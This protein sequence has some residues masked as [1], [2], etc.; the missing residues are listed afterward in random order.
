[1]AIATGPGD[2]R[3]ALFAL[4][5]A[6]LLAFAAGCASLW[7]WPRWPDWWLS[8]VVLAFVAAMSVAAWAAWCRQRWLVPVAAMLLG[9][10]WS[11]AQVERGLSQRLPA[12]L[13]AVD[14]V[15]EGHVDD[16][17]QRDAE[18]VR[19]RFCVQRAW[20]GAE[21]LALDGCWRLA[22]YAPR[23]VRVS[24]AQ[25][26]DAVPRIE[27]GQRW[28]L[29]VRLRRPRGLANPG[30]ADS[31]RKALETG[32][33]AAGY[34][35]AAGENVRL[36]AAGGI[37]ALRAGISDRIDDA[38][39]HGRERTAALLRGLAVGDRRDFDDR[40]WETL[41]RTG[42][43]HLFSIS[44][45]HVGMVAIV[46]AAL[47]TVLI[48]PWPRLLRRAPRRLWLLL[49]ALAAAF[50]YALLAGFEVPTQ[51][52]VLMIAAG[53]VAL[54]SRR[55]ICAWQAWCVALVLVLVIDPLAVLA[56]GFW[57]SFGGVAWLILAGTQQR[58]QGHWRRAAQVQWAV[59]LGLLPLGAGF[60]AQASWISPLV[61]GVAIPWITLG[62]VPP[63]LLS[64]ALEPM[65][66]A[67]AAPL[68]ALS[69]WL[70]EW[71]MAG[72]D[73]IAALS[74]TAS[75]LPEPGAL[76]IAAALL[77]ALVA[78]LP[79]AWPLRLL[80][81]PLLLPLLLPHHDRPPPGRFDLQV[82]DVGQGTAVL[83]RTARHALLFDAGPAFP[84]RRDLGE[85][86]VLP[87]L[88][89]LGVQR[90]DAL[91]L[92]HADLDH[93]GGG[94]AIL[95]ALPVTRVLAGE[96]V[97]GIDADA[98]HEHDAW[99]WDGVAFRL[100]HPP[101]GYP[102]RGNERSCV[103]HVRGVVG[104]A[105][106]TGDAGDIAELR[107]LNLHRDRLRAEV[108]LLGHH[109]SD[110]SSSAALL[111]AVQPRW[112]LASAGYRNR[113]GHPDTY[114]LRRLAWRGIAVASTIEAGAIH[115]QWPGDAIRVLGRRQRHPRLWHE[116]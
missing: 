31:E 27:P 101:P 81:L 113:F 42:T 39:G 74:W 8:P 3:A 48:W 46:V 56:I 36:S 12:A 92:S 38:L 53:G 102:T 4:T 47:A 49:P 7:L 5:P 28:R 21:S 45:L 18:A 72:L 112:A 41:R 1:M 91:L 30:G 83:V 19:F 2:T 37:H 10:A 104:S 55:R 67:V 60:F 69:A 99:D 75:V 32:L 85:T 50:G 100:L 70:L 77:A 40:D 87:A 35:R 78:L 13:E 68:L 57:L 103:L 88:R 22:W 15:A 54:A 62:V 44:G 51:R 107:L 66:P 14:L 82:F 61:N 116:P 110:G 33:T 90:L 98:C 58:G 73:R 80:S 105:L 94:A 65:L 26:S 34:V 86:V 6:S 109:G 84:G 16:L 79:L 23:D 29:S 97:P 9:V 24:G 93:A 43:T 71:L 95:R 63:L 106:L 114:V 64:V 89:V 76:A 20:R 17:P 115:V 111:A 59:T 25:R 96:P 52:T 11:L 108:L